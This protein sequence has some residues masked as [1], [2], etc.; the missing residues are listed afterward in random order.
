LRCSS[1]RRCQILP[2]VDDGDSLTGVNILLR[3]VRF[4][5]NGNALGAI[6]DRE[7]AQAFF[8][9]WFDPR[10]SEPVLRTQLLGES[11]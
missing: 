4:Y 5:R 10:T 9:I 6:E 7:F 8:A 2:D 3:G 1:G 11:R